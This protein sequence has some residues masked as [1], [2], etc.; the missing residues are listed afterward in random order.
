MLH[1]ENVTYWLSRQQD[2]LPTNRFDGLVNSISVTDRSEGQRLIA[3]T[4]HATAR[5]G[6]FIGAV[7]TDAV[8][9]DAGKKIAKTFS[10]RR[11]STP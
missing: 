1:Q 11:P 3:Q 4:T 8:F 5:V 10:V 7:F 9:T 6:A 2:M